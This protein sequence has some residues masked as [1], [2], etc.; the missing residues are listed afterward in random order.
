MGPKV[1]I[2][3]HVDN[4]A[5]VVFVLFLEMLEYPYFLLCLA[6]EP[7]LVSYHFKRDVLVCL[8]VVHFENLTEGPFADDFEYLVSVGYVIVGDVC[9][10]ALVIIVATIVL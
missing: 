10:G 4:I 2:V 8:V 6:V 3:K 9:V 5:C 1:E 7:F